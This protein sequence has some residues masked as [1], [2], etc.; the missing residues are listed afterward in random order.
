MPWSEHYPQRFSS[1]DESV[2]VPGAQVDFLDVGCGYGGL[3]GACFL[4][5]NY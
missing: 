1:E 2:R 4:Y 5:P 3:L